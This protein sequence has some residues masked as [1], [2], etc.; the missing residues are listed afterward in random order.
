MLTLSRNCGKNAVANT[1]TVRK[2][3]FPFLPLPLIRLPPLMIQ[4]VLM[5][6]YRA[7]KVR[8]RPPPPLQ[9]LDFDP[10]EI[11]YPRS[12]NWVPPPEVAQ[13]VQ[14]NLRKSFD[15][16]VRSRLKAE[17][18]RPDLEGK[19]SETP[20][21]DPTMVT[22]M[23]KFAKD[24][25]KGLDRSWRSCQDKL[26]DL[27]GPLTKILE[28]AYVAK[29][30]GSPVDTDVLIGWAQRAVCLLG[31]SNCA[32]SA[33]RR[34]SVLMRIDP[35][36][37]DVASSEAGPSAE[38]LLFGSSF[39]KDLAKF[40]STFSSLDKA[41]M[42]LKN[43]FKQG[44]FGRAGRY[45]GRMSSRSSFTSPQNYY[46]RGRGGWYGDQ[47]STFYSTRPRGGRPRFRR[48]HRRG[49]QG[50]IHDSS[51]TEDF[52][53]FSGRVN[54]W[55]SWHSHSVYRQPLGASRSY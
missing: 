18:P 51:F 22:F 44:L 43:V 1:V 25:K 34:K 30:S 46:P 4:M 15:K 52:Y 10:T 14:A 5:T 12:S 7:R 40:C 38:G 33:E 42:S 27:S 9:V 55:S 35:K 36:L 29:E 31:N 16:E 20:E 3:E 11:I 24:P 17:C 26:L 41:Q 53:N 2:K 23:K 37:S 8:K 49:Q 21:I 32:I 6:L 13:Y 54:A 50:A 28:L 19:V 45:G 48:G 47:D 39:I